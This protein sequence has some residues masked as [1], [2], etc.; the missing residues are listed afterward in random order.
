[1]GLKTVGEFAETEGLIR[2]LR[3]LG[4]DYAQGC[5]VQAP[6]PLPAA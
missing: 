2:E 1:M 4:V 5:G 3:R 6:Q